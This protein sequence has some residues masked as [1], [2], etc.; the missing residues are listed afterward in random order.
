MIYTNPNESNAKYKVKERYSNFIDGSWTE[1]Q[2]GEYFDNISPITGDNYAKV[3][4]SS[5]KDVD[6]AVK[7]AKKAQVEWGKSH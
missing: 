3:P 7:A 4:R 5:Q 1:P 6:L 2:E